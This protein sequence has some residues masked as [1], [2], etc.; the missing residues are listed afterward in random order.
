M[1][2]LTIGV[3]VAVA[4]LLAF[5]NGANDN[6]KGV[7]TLIGSRTIPL[8]P[9][10][11]YAAATTLA[12]SVTAVFLAGELLRRFTGKGLVDETLL[13]NGAF[14][15][16]TAA[17]AAMTVLMA[18]RMGMPISTTH[19]LVGAM[20]G[21]GAAASG[22]NWAM[23][24]DVFFYPLLASPVLAMALA[25]GIYLPLRAARRAMKID[26][27][28][29]ICVERRY[30]PVTVHGDGSVAAKAT[31]LRL[32]AADMSDC[33]VRYSGRVAGVEA[34]RLLDWSHVASAGA[35][36][37]ARGLNDT[38][39]IA[40]VMI[41]A[42]GLGDAPALV[43][44]GAAITAGGLLAVKRVAKTISYHITDMNHGQ[45][46]TANLVTAVLVILASRQGLPVSTTHVSCGSLFGI[47]AVNR[48]GNWRMIG[49]IVL[50]WV[51]TLP[52]AAAL[53]FV[54]WHLFNH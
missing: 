18:T 45:A 15:L 54:V 40:A 32:G 28:T 24:V 49:R 27:Q 9:A 1:T 5:A 30:L 3:V 22:L 33:V 44:V 20:I 26:H 50:A 43:T 29:C 53:G 52:V 25:A 7:A 4:L 10:I 13:T 47:G 6:A 14:A 35:I 21:I 34:Q 46:F 42:G 12:G 17:A 23:V 11:L 51:T 16:A 8:R 39:K 48:Q 38:P 37:F 36:S 41:A 2:T 19:A 31:G